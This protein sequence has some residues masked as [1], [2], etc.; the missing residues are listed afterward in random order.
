MIAAPHPLAAKTGLEILRAGGSASDAATAA[1][2]VLTLVEPQSSGIGG[3]G[4]LLHWDGRGRDLKSYDGR[5][6]APKAATPELFLDQGRALPFAAVATGGRAV[7]VPGLLRLLEL[8]HREHGRLEWRILVE[9]AVRAAENGFP[10]SARLAQLLAQEA[11]ADWPEPARKY[12]YRADGSAPQ[13]GDWMRN[14]DLAQTLRRI[15]REGA[16][17]FYRGPNARAVAAAVRGDTVNPGLLSV[18]DLADY[19]ARSRPP[20]CGPYRLYRICGVGPP[21]S[22]GVAVL[23]I[24]KIL[25]GFDLGSKPLAPDAVHLFAEA[26]RLAYADRA[27][28]LADSDFVPV[29]LA[30]LIDAE[31]LQGR[32]ALVALDRSM[33]QAPPGLPPGGDL[34]RGAAKGQHGGTSHIT[35]VDGWGNIAAL[36]TTIQAAFGSRL[37]VKGFLLNNEL[38]DF[39]FAPIADG[40]PVANRVEG[41]KRPLSSMAPTIVFDTG[42]KP[43]LALGSPGG[44]AIINYVAKTIVAVLD[45]RLDAARA[46]AMANFGSRNGKTELEKSRP[47]LD[48]AR[49]ALETYGH[50]IA[51]IDMPSGVQAIALD[52]GKLMGAAD[53]RREGVA[54]GD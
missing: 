31:Y 47:E 20:L 38:T 50:E 27:L 14:P 30:G 5:E 48:H 11:K 3:G 46:V 52:E 16:E 51:L 2:L 6:T 25:E 41:G 21:S 18:R 32:R 26:G 39:A 15:A 40:K 53:P 42:M 19:R 9:P 33:G 7:G 12:F 28:Y 17:A 49:A 4:F 34:R 8:A 24:L 13:A 43:V 45:W 54:L 44:S 1:A 22:G 10:I 37:M 29:P 36:T 23:Q 35:V